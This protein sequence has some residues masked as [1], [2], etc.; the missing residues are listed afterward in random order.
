MS[1]KSFWKK[2]ITWRDFIV[3]C[4]VFYISISVI[5]PTFDHMNSLVKDLRLR[6]EVRSTVIDALAI[7]NDLSI[8]EAK[9]SEIIKSLQNKAYRINASIKSESRKYTDESIKDLD[10]SSMKEE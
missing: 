8:S 10:I 3:F 1:H 2:N 4:A 6:S 7:K 5:N 9:K